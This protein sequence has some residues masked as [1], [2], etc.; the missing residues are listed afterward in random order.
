MSRNEKL[1]LSFHQYFI[2]RNLAS[3][4]SHKSASFASI[5]KTFVHE[6][7]EIGY[8]IKHNKDI[9]LKNKPLIMDRTTCKYL[10]KAMNGIARMFGVLRSET[11]LFFVSPPSELGNILALNLSKTSELC[12]REA[13]CKTM[14]SQLPG[15]I[16]NLLFRNQAKKID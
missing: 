13:V 14:L 4:Q 7:L 10:R 3:C 8:A 6:T 5:Y 16:I 2:K 9:L 15:V 11:V 1:Y 12:K